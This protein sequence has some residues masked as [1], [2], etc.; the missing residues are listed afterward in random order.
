[1][2]KELENGLSVVFSEAALKS[3]F[4]AWSRERSMMRKA[5]SL[6]ELIRFKEPKKRRESLTEK[7]RDVF[8]RDYRWLRELC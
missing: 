1:M 2:M 6:D 3:Q 4:I 8:D 7:E 5:D